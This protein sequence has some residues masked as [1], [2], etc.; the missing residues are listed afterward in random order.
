MICCV[1]VMSQIFMLYKFDCPHNKIFYRIRGSVS[2]FDLFRGRHQVWTRRTHTLKYQPKN[3]E[4]VIK[5]GKVSY[6][7][8]AIPIRAQAIV[9]EKIK[10]ARLWQSTTKSPTSPRHMITM[11]EFMT[12][13]IAGIS[14]QKFKMVMNKVHAK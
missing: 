6:C 14:I 11:V 4:A 9:A 8:I 3:K 7:F 13:L 2:L 10:S 1:T 12:V 5:I